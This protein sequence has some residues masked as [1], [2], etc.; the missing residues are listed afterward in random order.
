MEQP[1]S[2]AGID[3]QQEA[4][5][6]HPELLNQTDEK[7]TEAEDST[8]G[9]SGGNSQNNCKRYVLRPKIHHS[10]HGSRRRTNQQHTSKPSLSNGE[11]TYAASRPTSPQQAIA[12]TRKDDLP[13][14]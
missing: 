12:T 8:E 4:Q 2:D 6:N 14:D 3:F 1:S 10:N 11:L 13:H 9:S 7:S 5:D